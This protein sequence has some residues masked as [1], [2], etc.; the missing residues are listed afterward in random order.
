MATLR[1][2]RRKAVERAYQI[3]REEYLENCGDPDAAIVAAQNRL[4]AEAKPGSIIL[5][6]AIGV[7]VSLIARFIWEWITSDTAEPSVE[8]DPKLYD[9]AEEV[10]QHDDV[11]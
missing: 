3:A 7:L 2:R 10:I 1:T 9:F 11:D 5:T 6:I 4:R 8:F